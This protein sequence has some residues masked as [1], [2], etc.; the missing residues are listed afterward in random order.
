MP[1]APDA[2]VVRGAAAG[3]KTVDVAEVSG[4]GGAVVGSRTVG[5]AGELD[6]CVL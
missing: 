6:A 3:S 5:E 1:G 4:A 2:V